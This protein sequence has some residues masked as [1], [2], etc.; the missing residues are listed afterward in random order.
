MWKATGG[1]GEHEVE[2]DT[3]KACLEA[4][5]DAYPEARPRLFDEDGQIHYYL[6]ISVG[7]RVV[8]V[9]RIRPS[10]PTTK[11]SLCRRF[12]EEGDDQEATRSADWPERTRLNL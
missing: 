8:Q 9:C 4:L 1:Q 12:R 5:I 3:V 6:T 7:G 2:G 11:S 10:N